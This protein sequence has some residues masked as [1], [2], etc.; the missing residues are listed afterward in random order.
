MTKTD[1]K[2]LLHRL[3]AALADPATS[4]EELAGFFTSD[5]VQIVDGETLNLAGFLD[6][7]ATLRCTLD[8]VDVDFEN[9]VASDNTIADIHIVTAHKKDGSQI[10]I[11]VIAFYTLRDG[12]ISRIEE[13]T[14]LISGSTADRD[15]GSR[16]DR[17]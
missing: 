2:Q 7:A 14:H 5:Y 1:A 15:I 12:K 3:F 4:L 13:L 16:I 8:A 11:K 9:I 10:T 6:H 17:A